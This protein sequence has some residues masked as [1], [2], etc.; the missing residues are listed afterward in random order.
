MS[1]IAALLPL[2]LLTQQPPVTVI[3]VANDAPTKAKSY[4]W[5]ERHEQVVDRVNKGNVGLLMIGDSIT[6]G[7]WTS[8]G[9]DTSLGRR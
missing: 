6:H 7:T 8:G 5:M 9:S 3:P 4:N 2:F 1:F